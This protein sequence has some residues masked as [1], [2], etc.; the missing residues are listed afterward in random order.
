M[1]AIKAQVHKGDCLE[2]LRT[3]DDKSVDL[4]YLDPPFFTQKTHTLGTRDRTRAFSFEDLWSS[5]TEY[6]RFIH[7]RLEQMWRVLASTGA[8]FFHCDRNA[9]QKHVRRTETV[10]LTDDL[11]TIEIMRRTEKAKTCVWR[12]H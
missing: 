7:A 4:I 12:W 1:Q 10:L 11:G 3:R 5:H 9:A 6:A 8:L 2:I